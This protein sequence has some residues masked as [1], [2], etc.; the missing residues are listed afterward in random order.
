MSK[1]SRQIRVVSSVEG[2][3]LKVGIGRHTEVWDVDGV[4]K[5]LR[6]GVNKVH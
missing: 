3:A 1:G 4:D 2:L 5:G 6:A